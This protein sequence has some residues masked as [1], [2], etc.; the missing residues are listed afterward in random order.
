M[1][2]TSRNSL[3]EESNATNL[4]VAEYHDLM[5]VKRRRLAIDVLSDQAGPVDVEELAAEIA[6]RTE[7]LDADDRTDVDRVA[8]TLH[9]VHL[10]KMAALDILE[11]DTADTLVELQ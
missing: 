11:Y 4:T 10:P 5:A 1:S 6:A 3:I 2:R 8:I 9:H 7:E